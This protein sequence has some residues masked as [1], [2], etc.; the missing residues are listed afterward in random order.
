MIWKGV[1]HTIVSELIAYILLALIVVVLAFVGV[2]NVSG[3]LLMLVGLTLFFIVYH[4][5]YRRR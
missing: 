3:T 5:R 4:V 2:T 1:G